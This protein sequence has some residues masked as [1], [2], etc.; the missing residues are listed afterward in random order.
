MGVRAL[1]IIQNN[2]LNGDIGG[3]LERIRNRIFSMG[4]FGFEPWHA[5]G[6][7]FRSQSSADNTITAITFS[8][9]P[10]SVILIHGSEVIAGDQSLIHIFAM[11][12]YAAANTTLRIEGNVAR[13]GDFTIRFGA[14]VYK[15]NQ[16]GIFLD[17]EYLPVTNMSSNYQMLFED[18]I[19]M[20]DINVAFL[21]CPEVKPD[22]DYNFHN[23]GV[24]YTKMLLKNDIRL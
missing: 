5:T 4:A 2:N 11:L 15:D 21:F 12:E 13:I 18:V 9:S 22:C 7:V 8:D 14:A 6:R 23:L 10:D 19:K 20:M 16:I 3:Y 17:I 24:Q 1:G